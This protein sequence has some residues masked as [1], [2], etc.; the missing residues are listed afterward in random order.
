MPPELLAP[1]SHGSL[2]R[3][4]RSSERNYSNAT[5][6]V[7]DCEF[8]LGVFANRLIRPGEFILGFS[9]P[10]IDFAETKRRGDWECMAFQIGPNSYFDTLAPGVFVNHSCAPNAGVRNDRDLVALCRIQKGEEIRFDYST[11]MEERSF[12]MRCR[13]GAPNCRQVITDFS[14]LPVELQHRYLSQG[15]VMN[16][17]AERARALPASALPTSVFW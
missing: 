6:Y 3:N 15:L 13:C 16:F 8:G 9:G 14:E 12:T 2:S 5:L 11:T 10:L 1:P 4:P 17:I 7:G